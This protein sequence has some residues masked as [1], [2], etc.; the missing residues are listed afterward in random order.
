ASVITLVVS[1]SELLPGLESVVV[2][3]T[4]AVLVIVV[5]C[6]TL[7]FTRTTRV[8]ERVLAELVVPAQVQVTLP[9]PFTGG[10]AQEPPELGVADWKVVFAGIGSVIVTFCA[11]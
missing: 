5:P 6:G 7:E 2:E 4:V 10:V 11:S 3:L 1:V 9:V 8:S